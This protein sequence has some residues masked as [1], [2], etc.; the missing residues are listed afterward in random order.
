MRKL[1]PVALIL[2]GVG[3]AT[4]TGG[5]R[6]PQSPF[7]TVFAEYAV[8][9]ALGKAL[10]G[11][12]GGWDEGISLR[13]WIQ[14]WTH[15]PSDADADKAF[16]NYGLHPLAGS[17]T[18]MIARAHGWTFGEA[19]LFDAA[20]SV[21]WEYVFENVY[22]R[23][24]RTDLMVTAPVGALLGELR[25]QAKQ[26]GAPPWLVDPVGDHGRVFVEMDRDGGVMLGLERK[27]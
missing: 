20:A 24:S 23:P 14:G 22:E 26:A 27:F 1:L 11:Q 16:V 12:V 21:G 2:A 8:P 18:H 5:G 9:V 6:E 13:R 15:K 3:C 7:A 4:P 10:P 17:E 19:A 25:W